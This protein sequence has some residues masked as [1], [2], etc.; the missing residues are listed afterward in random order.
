MEKPPLEIAKPELITHILT[1][2]QALEKSLQGLTSD[3]M[4]LPGVSGDWSV[5]DI[6]AHITVWEQRMVAW[7][8]AALAGEA[9]VLPA[10]DQEADLWNAQTYQENRDRPLEDI[11]AESGASYHQALEAVTAAP[12]ID[13]ADAHRFPWRSGS[14]LWWMVAANTWWHYDEHAEAIRHWREESQKLMPGEGTD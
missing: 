6:L 12:E 5:K 1:S 7:L 9:P 2:R 14:P 4:A 10:S 13:L 11:R 8:Q 3:Q